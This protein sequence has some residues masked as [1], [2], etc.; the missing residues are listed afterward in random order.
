MGARTA[1]SAAGTLAF[2]A[3]T[4]S[5]AAQDIRQYEDAPVVRVYS[6][7]G[8]GISAY[9][10]PVI[11]VREDSY[12]MVI[13]VDLD[14][15]VQ[16]LYPAYP[17]HDGFMEARQRERLPNFFAG[18][19]RNRM[20]ISDP[21]Y[22]SY[23]FGTYSNYEPAITDAR[24]TVI[25]IA[26]RT[27]LNFTSLSR[28]GDWNYAAIARLVSSRNPNSLALALARQLGATGDQ[29]GYDIFRF[30]GGQTYYAS[31]FPSCDL[32]YGNAFGV[33]YLQYAALNARL[34]G[35][36]NG[37]LRIIGYDQCGNPYV[38]F[39]P[40]RL[41]NPVRPSS[42]PLPGD[43]VLKQFPEDRLP[44]RR[45]RPGSASE[46]PVTVGTFP[47]ARNP[48]AE[49]ARGDFPVTN[50]AP[51][52]LRPIPASPQASP[53]APRSFPERLQP[54]RSEPVAAPRSETAPPRLLPP[55]ERN[56]EPVRHPEP[57]RRAEP[58]HAPAPAPVIRDRPEP[59][60]QPVRERVSPS[61]LPAALDR[62]A[63][64][65]PAN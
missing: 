45:P 7:S 50:A 16:V 56:P 36:R 63:V 33:G 40:E 43:T 65:P 1:M 54:A 21:L 13:S 48:R 10:T 37:S 57:V 9:I 17:D 62:P 61:P 51:P 8:G 44:R 46:E 26:S 64:P 6:Q 11:E 3:G 14:R 35:A 32:V 55:R 34:A 15:D 31:A 20:V 53:Q 60:P 4:A 23:R 58:V 24:G 12:V 59:A 22:S 38:T 27:P 30:A 28:R 47:L 41:N 5:A 52:R 42:P 2:L 39:L 29:V 49:P 19:A 18:H 25:A